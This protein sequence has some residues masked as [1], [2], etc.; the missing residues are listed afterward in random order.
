MGVL[1]FKEEVE[2]RAMLGALPRFF[3]ACLPFPSPLSALP[4]KL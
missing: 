1:G 4:H 2:T 3:S